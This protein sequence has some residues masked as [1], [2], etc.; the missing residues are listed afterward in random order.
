MAF[1]VR[2]I[3]LASNPEANSR[4]ARTTDVHNS[5][6]NADEDWDEENDPWDRVHQQV[7]DP[8]RRKDLASLVKSAKAE[9]K[10]LQEFELTDQN[11]NKVSSESLRGQPYV[12][13]FFFTTCTGTCPRQ[14]SQMQLLQNKLKGRP[15]R[16]VS[17]TVDPEVDTPE[18]LKKYS[19]KFGADPERW[20]F[21]HGSMDYIS[22]I[23]MQKFF[24][25]G[26]KERGHPDRFV[27]VN[28]EGDPV[29]SYLWL[30]I[31]EREELNKHIE[32]L[33]QN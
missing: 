26:V 21:L 6:A 2:S 33:L 11:G 7:E 1:T 30:D 17:I 32:E 4:G 20:F 15:I 19:E 14:T 25:D 18:V 27:L 10:W 31:D 13:C 3:R 8:G 24:L 22:E 16:F 23:G 12:A 9:P 28:A 5:G 29:G